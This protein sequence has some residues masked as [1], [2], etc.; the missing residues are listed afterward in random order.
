MARAKSRPADDDDEDF[1]LDSLPDDDAESVAEASELEVAPAALEPEVPQNRQERRRER[2]RLRQDN[3]RLRQ[4]VED[5]AREQAY[6]K[7][8]ASQYPDA[9]TLY[10]SLNGGAKPQG[11]PYQAEID[12]CL[13]QASRIG[14][15]YDALVASKAITVEARDRLQRELNQVE[16][17]KTE[18]ITRRV[19]ASQQAQA[20]DPQQIAQ[21]AILLQQ[22]ARNPDVYGNAAALNYARAEYQARV[23]G[24]EPAGDDT[25]EE[26]MEAARKRFKMKPKYER[27]PATQSERG[28]MTGVG[29][30]ASGTGAARSKGITI[31]PTIRAIADEMFA[32]EP[33][34]ARRVQLWV[35]T[36]G[37]KMLEE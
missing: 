20:P 31:T 12:Q 22:Q 16:A 14:R 10:Q 13:E 23:A 29:R 24:G 18:A 28:R 19:I 17:R 5:L 27:G 35:N 6:L 26:A 33:N 37:R 7:G 4:Q 21:R 34:A 15:E 30:G 3:E 2:G 8:V 32:K 11:D 9:N 1:D 36:V 25:A